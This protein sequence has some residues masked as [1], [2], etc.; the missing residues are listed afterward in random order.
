MRGRSRSLPPA[1]TVQPLEHTLTALGTGTARSTVTVRVQV[2][3]QLT[4][5]PSPRASSCTPATCWRRS[6]RARTRRRWPTPRANL[7]RDDAQLQN[8][9]VDLERYRGLMAEDSIPKQQLDTQEALVRQFKGTVNSDQRADPDRRAEP[10]LYAR[11]RAGQRPR[12]PAPGRRRQHR[13]RRRHH[14][15]GRAHRGAAH[16]RRVPGAAGRAAGDLA[17][18][19]RRR[20]ACSSKPSI[21]TARTLLGTGRLRSVD[22]L[23]DTTTGTV[24]LK[25]ANSPTARWRSFPTSS[26]TCACAWRPSPDA[27]ADPDGGR[28]ARRA[29]QLRL[30]RAGRRHRH[31][32]V[33]K[34]GITEGDRVQVLDGLASGDDGRDRRHRQAARRR[35]GR[36]HRPGAAAAAALPGAAARRRHGRRGRAQAPQARS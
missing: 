19:A 34:L 1:A 28:A 27:L 22:N 12:R 31:V 32:R 33:P 10:G 35:P 26:S 21:A 14:R 30:R 8:A 16:R 24:K 36:G 23:I 5:W 4:R 9:L 3:G 13:A 11:H 29:G 2:D 15:P 25:G 20:A 17:A 7:E 18:H 6:T